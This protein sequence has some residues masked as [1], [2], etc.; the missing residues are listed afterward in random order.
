[1]DILRLAGVPGVGKSTVAWAVAR[2]LTA[3][4][5][6]VGYVDI[7]QL[8]MCYPA[9]SE[10][11]DRWD[12]KENAL[13]RVA[14]S[15]AAAGVE[16]LVVS[17]VADPADPP[18][19]NGHPTVSL[20]LDADEAT[21]RV[22]LAPR[23]WPQK[24]VDDVLAVG[25]AE[26]AAAHPAWARVATDGSAVEETVRIV[27]ERPS[28]GSVATP[29]EF[30]R[31]EPDVAGRIIWITGPRCAGASS[32]GWEIAAESWRAGQ[33]TGF[34]DVAQLGFVWNVDRT[35]GLRN[36]TSLQRLFAGAGARTLVAVAPFETSPAAVRD[37][38]PGSDIR[39]FRLDAD[40]D[41]RRARALQGAAGTGPLLA[42]DDLIGASPQAV[43]D[44]V[45]LGAR[46]RQTPV[47]AGE[48]LIGRA[49]MSASEVAEQVRAHL[50]D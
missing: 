29:A 49:G 9:P 35:V 14:R 33:R 27:L 23:G 25:T 30:P 26:A 8:G 16:R 36:T 44:I 19:A 20:W 40:D 18:R 21:R 11:P 22:R 2:Q 41:T 32:V 43:D 1:M 39:F 46:Q 7:D 28:P 34:V 37:A 17:G 45:A 24:Q 6:R 48:L 47:R 50:P 5:V 10:D 31:R 38:F 4:G 12:L 42:G 13:R 3:D 15:F